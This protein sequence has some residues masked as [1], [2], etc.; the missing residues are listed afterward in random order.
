MTVKGLRAS[1]N[2]MVVGWIAQDLV[3]GHFESLRACAAYGLAR[4]SKMAQFL[5]TA[6]S[7]TC[8]LLRTLD[9]LAGDSSVITR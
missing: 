5:K 6:I 4:H 9:L 3:S 7:I 2:P 1:I 8:K